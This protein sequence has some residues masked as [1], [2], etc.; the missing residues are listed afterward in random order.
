[1]VLTLQRRPWR[2]CL[3]DAVRALT[4]S[5]VNSS[6]NLGACCTTSKMV[7]IGATGSAH[8]FSGCPDICCALKGRV[9]SS[10]TA[11]RTGYQILWLAKACNLLLGVQVLN[12]ICLVHVIRC[13]HVIRLVI[14]SNRCKPC[15]CLEGLQLVLQ[16][17]CKHVISLVILALPL[18][19]L[20]D[21][22]S[23]C[24]MHM[25]MNSKLLMQCK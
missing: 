12:V 7:M 18:V 9:N 10:C 3:Q 14:W 22:L 6:I 21:Q 16:K 1:M 2:S 24:P 20:L 8:L 25:Y 11:A 5:G 17:R 15:M 4:P 19:H 13:D 23:C